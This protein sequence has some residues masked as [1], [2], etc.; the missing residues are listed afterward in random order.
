MPKRTIYW[1]VQGAI[2]VE[3]LPQVGFVNPIEG[4]TQVDVPVV[5]TVFSLIARDALGQKKT[6]QFIMNPDG[7]SG[8]VF[9]PLQPHYEI[10]RASCRERV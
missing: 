9:P 4:S 3:I 10:G 6:A 5:P 2:S 8:H 1:R 7:T